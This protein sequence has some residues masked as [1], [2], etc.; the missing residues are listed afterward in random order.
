MES[1]QEATD[2]VSVT[3]EESGEDSELLA[4]G[5]RTARSETVRQEHASRVSKRS[6]VFTL[7]GSQAVAGVR[8]PWLEK[9]QQ[10]QVPVTKT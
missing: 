2:E 10:T 5:S 3:G 1:W 6:Q 8:D 9:Y 4:T 7:T